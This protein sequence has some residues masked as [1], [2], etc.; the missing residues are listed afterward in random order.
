MPGPAGPASACACA[1]SRT[2][3]GASACPACTTRATRWR[4]CASP[5][6]SASRS[7]PPAR[8]WPASR[9]S[10]AASRCAARSAAC[11]S[12]TTTA[13]TPPSSRRRSRPRA[14]YGR[15]LVVAFQPHRYTRTRDLLADFAPSLA[16]ADQLFVTDIYAA[17]ESP[18]PG[19]DT[20]ALLATF[21]HGAAVRKVER[22]ALAPAL[23]EAVRAGDLVL[24][25]GAGDITGVPTEL[26]ALLGAEGPCRERAARSVADAARTVVVDKPRRGEAG[27][28]G[29]ATGASRCRARRWGVAGGGVRAIGRKLVVL[30]KAAVVVAF[31]AASVFAVRA[32]VR[33]VVASPRFAVHDV[34]V[35]FATAAKDAASATT[36]HVT[37]DEV[38]E[39]AGRRARRPAAG[40]R[41]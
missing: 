32:V 3:R 1:A 27:S 22:G 28:S 21:P 39:L 13:T 4:R 10:T 8:R 33:H 24:C 12:S 34:R 37:A 41:R 16:G 40:G 26:L 30:A 9:A 31:V 25:L 19:V 14:C 29:A 23:A 5:T 11:W 38:R 18:L 2:A 35:T 15:R 6:S 20:D 36:T 17:G 7:R